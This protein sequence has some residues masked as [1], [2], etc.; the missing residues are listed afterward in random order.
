MA[1]QGAPSY[2]RC[3]DSPW[4]YCRCEGC[5]QGL[6]PSGLFLTDTCWRALSCSKAWPR[7]KVGLGSMPPALKTKKER[8][9]ERCNIC[10]HGAGGHQ[11]GPDW[12]DLWG[13]FCAPHT[14]AAPHTPGA[15][16]KVQQLSQALILLRPAQAVRHRLCCAPQLCS[17]FS[18]TIP[19]C[20]SG[21]SGP[22]MHGR[23]MMT[24]AASEWEREV[25][26]SE[27]DLCGGP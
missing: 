14:N 12:P 22:S 5:V 24:T 9:R 1:G 26:A 25:S 3:R 10:W 13:A 7:V 17:I 8:A 4:S 20:D 21:A 23:L 19:T 27:A 16:Q 18:T 6:L 11:R 2:A 15:V